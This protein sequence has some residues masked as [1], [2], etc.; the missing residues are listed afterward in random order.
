MVAAQEEA[1]HEHDRPR[2]PVTTLDSLTEPIPEDIEARDVAGVL[3]LGLA[4]FGAARL[5]FVTGFGAE[6]MV[7]LD[8][9]MRLV[10]QPRIVTLDTGRLP[11][12]TH[13]LIDR[14]R[15]RYRIHVEVVFPEATDVEA[16]VGER[17][18]DLFYR[19]LEDRVRCCDVRKVRPLARVLA[20][21][22]GWITGLR[23]DQSVDPGGDPQDRPGPRQRHDLEGLP[24]R[25]L[26]VGPGLDLHP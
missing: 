20:G 13:E 4:T 19:S 24:A 22:G 11:D 12:A 8:V 14:V 5:P 9:L 10:P 25:R 17:G 21:A 2:G 6:G 3:A 7:I 1:P 18:A 16:M 23:R 26:V 15:E